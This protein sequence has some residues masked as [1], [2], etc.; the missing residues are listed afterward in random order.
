M[1][2]HNQD[3]AVSGTGISLIIAVVLLLTVAVFG[4]WSFASRQ[5]FKNNVDA[6]I[7]VAVAAAQQQASI[8]ENAK[9]A[10]DVKQPYYTFNGPAQY[11]SISFKYPKTWSAYVNGI[12]S[13]NSGLI[14]GYFTPGILGT[15]T[16]GTTDFALRIKVL[17]QA[18][19]GVVQEF[20]G[21]TIRKNGI[22]A[23]TYTLPLVPNIVGTEVSGKL[24]VSSANGTS[25]M[26][27]L[28]ERT[29]TIE[30]WTDGNTFL[31]DFNNAILKSFTFSP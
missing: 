1:I 30:I 11:G 23:S 7:S 31:D 24:S 25:T 13:S 6:K 9:F 28:P 4:G 10:Q 18:Y 3:G 27:I 29:Y 2:K 8:V 16:D 17:N 22:K 20:A 15:V 26:V 19:S 12:S 14:D 5:D 21:Q